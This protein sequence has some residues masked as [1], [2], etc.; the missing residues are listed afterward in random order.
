ML[1]MPSY[2][3]S[4][5]YDRKTDTLDIMAPDELKEEY[6]IR[7]ESYRDNQDIIR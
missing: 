5:Y 2:Y 1:S 7:H 4:E 3:F 6:A